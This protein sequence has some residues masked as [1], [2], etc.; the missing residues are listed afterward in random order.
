M[1]AL[2]TAL[3]LTRARRSTLRSDEARVR[4]VAATLAPEPCAGRRLAPAQRLRA[5]GLYQHLRACGRSA[6]LAALLVSHLFGVA[7]DTVAQWA[8]TRLSALN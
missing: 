6:Q 8:S 2:A 3:P 1:N 4:R 5:V 7:P